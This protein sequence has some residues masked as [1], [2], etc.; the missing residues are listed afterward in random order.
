[1]M[2]DHAFCFQLSQGTNEFAMYG[3]RG[4][5]ILLYMVQGDNLDGG[6]FKV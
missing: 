2:G 1:M 3:P 5:Y 4:Q 6:Q